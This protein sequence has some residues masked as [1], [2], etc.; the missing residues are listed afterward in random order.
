MIRLS[1]VIYPD[2]SYYPNA[3]CW[4]VHIVLNRYNDILLPVSMKIFARSVDDQFRF[5]F[6]DK[7]YKSHIQA[8][9]LFIIFS[10][11]F[12]AVP[13]NIVL[14]Y[15]L[16]IDGESHIQWNCMPH[17]TSTMQKSFSCIT[18]SVFQAHF[19]KKENKIGHSQIK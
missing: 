1:L 8:N 19:Q 18:F 13:L 16:V 15:K 7:D 5:H 6:S 4:K 9:G 14:F 11:M 10:V 17:N 12:C 2:I 3:L